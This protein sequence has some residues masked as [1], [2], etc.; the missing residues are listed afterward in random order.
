MPK[1]I[2]IFVFAMSFSGAKAS[3]QLHEHQARL[4]AKYPFGLIG[5]D[6]GI[7]NTN[8]L[9]KNTRVAPPQPLSEK[10]TAYPYWQCFHLKNMYF[11]CD[12]TYDE[13][14]KTTWTILAIGARE[15]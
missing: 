9:Y 1:V 11:E 3:E 7:L 8:D 13:S 12:G 10:S 5:D 6:H 14:D 4:R 2:A 15:N